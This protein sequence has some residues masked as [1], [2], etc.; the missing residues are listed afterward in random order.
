MGFLALKGHSVNRPGQCEAP[1]WLTGDPRE[2]SLFH[3]P[4]RARPRRADGKSLAFVSASRETPGAAALYPGL[5]TSA[6]S[7][8]RQGFENAPSLPWKPKPPNFT[9]NSGHTQRFGPIRND[10]ARWA[11]L[12][13]AHRERDPRPSSRKSRAPEDTPASINRR[14]DAQRIETRN[15]VLGNDLVTQSR[16]LRCVRSADSIRCPHSFVRS[17]KSAKRSSKDGQVDHACRE[18]T[19]DDADDSVLSTGIG[20]ADERV[21]S[22]PR[23]CRDAGDNSVPASSRDSRRSRMPAAVV[24]HAAIGATDEPGNGTA[25]SLQAN[26]TKTIK[27]VLR[28]GFAMWLLDRT[29]G[30]RSGIE[31]DRRM[32]FDIDAILNSE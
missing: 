21:Y 7:G 15:S 8:Q 19:A 9:R 31:H 5:L 10:P 29:G 32:R 2:S 24:R 26:E 18:S 27:F 3:P 6:L 22:D 30:R 12:F 11:L 4:A 16:R 13:H 23:T 14:S 28:N 1:P 25:E 20:H 17:G